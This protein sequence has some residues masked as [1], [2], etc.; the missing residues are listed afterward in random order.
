LAASHSLARYVG[1]DPVAGADC[2]GGLL[3]EHPA[4]SQLYTSFLTPLYVPKLSPD[5]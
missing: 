1:V 2:G 3:I 5:E 4:V